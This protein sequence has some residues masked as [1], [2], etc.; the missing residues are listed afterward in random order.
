MTLLWRRLFDGAVSQFNS[1]RYIN[2]YNIGRLR[3]SKP[4]K[5]GYAIASGCR[6]GISV[7]G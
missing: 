1:C 5:V 3:S 7:S 4:P 2:E 6:A